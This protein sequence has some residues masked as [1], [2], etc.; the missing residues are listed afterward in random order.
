METPLA[1]NE[2]LSQ[3][4]E[5]GEAFRAEVLQEMKKL[6][7]LSLN[8]IGRKRQ[9]LNRVAESLGLA[10]PN[11]ATG[12]RAV[13]HFLPEHFTV[14]IHWYIRGKGCGG[15]RPAQGT[16]TLPYSDDSLDKIVQEF[17]TLVNCDR[18]N[19]PLSLQFS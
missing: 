15:A 16:L 18:F 5:G 19:S 11:S 1:D 17:E 8:S 13:F 3:I 7:K 14:E 12:T 4:I 9:S 2:V 10:F 6:G